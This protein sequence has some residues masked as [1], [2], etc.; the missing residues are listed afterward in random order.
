MTRPTFTELTAAFFDE[1][2]KKVEQEQAEKEE[3]LNLRTERPYSALLTQDEE[4]SADYSPLQI[5][6]QEPEVI[7]RFGT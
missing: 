3:G 7:T 6:Y 4:P 5:E 2:G 1:L